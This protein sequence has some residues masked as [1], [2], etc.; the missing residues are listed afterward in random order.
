MPAQ[1]AEGKA[2]AMTPNKSLR[3]ILVRALMKGDK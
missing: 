3:E 2:A 1:A